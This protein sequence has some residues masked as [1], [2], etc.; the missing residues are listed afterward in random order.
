MA[1]LVPAETKKWYVHC[2]S[3][4]RLRVVDRCQQKQKLISCL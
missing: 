3:I 1:L 4:N 2:S